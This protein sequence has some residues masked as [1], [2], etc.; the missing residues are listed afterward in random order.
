[1]ENLKDGSAYVKKFC[2]NKFDL[3][4]SSV[5]KQVLVLSAYSSF[6]KSQENIQSV[7]WFLT[8]INNYGEAPFT[9][10]AIS[11]KSNFCFA[12]IFQ[13]IEVRPHP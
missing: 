2:Q 4:S 7:A 3:T 1:M 9:R 11:Y 12:N 13:I 5:F 6:V 8:R 10:F